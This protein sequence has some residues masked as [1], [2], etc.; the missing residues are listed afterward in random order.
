MRFQLTSSYTACVST[1]AF[2]HRKPKAVVFLSGSLALRKLDPAFTAKLDNL[3]ARDCH[4]LLGDAN[5]TDKA[6]QQYL[7]KHDHWNAT[8]Y[9]SWKAVNNLG[10]WPEQLVSIHKQR[11]S[12]GFNDRK[13][14]AMA[15]AADCG[16][17]LWDGAHRLTLNH[18]RYL[19]E[20]GK[21]V[22]FY[23]AQ[24]KQFTRMAT[25][26]DLGRF[27][28]QHESTSRA[29]APKLARRMEKVLTDYKGER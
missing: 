26:A 19:L 17:M 2:D 7:L 24:T 9:R 14:E 15:R 6:I 16:L 13:G 18:A 10:D 28:Q 1:P 5:G 8:I 12:F 27:L 4:L 25:P 29:T 23:A 22:L 11:W 20:Q 21:P 3:I